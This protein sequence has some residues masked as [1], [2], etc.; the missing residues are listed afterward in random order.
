MREFSENYLSLDT[1]IGRSIIPFIF[2]PG[3][4]TKEFIIGKRTSFVN[5]FRFYLVISILFFF[6]LGTMINGT[7]DGG[8]EVVNVSEV[9]DNNSVSID[10]ISRDVAPTAVIEDGII[11]SDSVEAKKPTIGFSTD[12]KG[13]A[14]NMSELKKIQKYRYD[15]SYTD[16]QLVDSLAGGTNAKEVDGTYRYIAK[17]LIKAYRSDS[18]TFTKFILGNYS[19][20]MF[21]LIPLFAFML[22]FFY[23][24]NKLP[25]VAHLIHSLQLHT[26]GFFIY[27][28]GMVTILLN[29]NSQIMLFITFLLSALYIYFSCKRVYERSHF[30]TIMRV[31]TIG[32]FY[33]IMWAGI[34]VLGLI[35]SLLLF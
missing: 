28:I 6:L 29:A 15:K 33:Y 30:S 31:L 18:K 27:S 24:K 34:L 35:V 3:Q 1:R 9:T 13:L 14:I 19:I 25:F 2:K 4:L 16:D 21:L 32:F 17:Q 5:P 12:S 8:E 23:R 26:F 20:S 11:T 10:S 22:M 7:E